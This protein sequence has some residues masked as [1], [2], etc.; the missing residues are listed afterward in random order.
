MAKKKAKP[1]SAKA[2]A[3]ENES[4]EEALAELDAIVADLEGGE[5]GLDESLARYE[6]GVARLRRCHAEL[7]NAERKIELLSGV[8]AD[9]NPVT[10]PFDDE[11]TTEESPRSSKRTAASRKQRGVDDSSSLF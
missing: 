10:R 9:G 3:G 5:L 6:Q 2:S 8:D 1:K 11:A 7:D 4:F